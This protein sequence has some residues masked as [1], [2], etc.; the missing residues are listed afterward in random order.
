LFFAIGGIG[1]AAATIGTGDIKNGA[2]TKKKLHKNAVVSKK[3][4]NHSLKCKDLKK[5]CLRGARGAT[6]PRG[7]TGAIGAVGGTGPAGGVNYNTQLGTNG[8][9]SRSIGAFTLHTVTNANGDCGDT[10]LTSSAAAHYSAGIDYRDPF[11]GVALTAGTPVTVF[12]GSTGQERIVAETDN[13]ASQMIAVN[14]GCHSNVG[15]GAPP[16][17]SNTF[18]V[19]FGD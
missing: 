6:G 12:T 19:L 9:I 18:G 17:V 10:T 11:A 14:V 16:H 2:V 4:K 8:S 13:G 1:Y 3:V 5:G 15:G 7:A